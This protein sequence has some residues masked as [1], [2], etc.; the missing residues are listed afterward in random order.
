V[1][2]ACGLQPQGRWFDPSRAHRTPPANCALIRF[3]VIRPAETLLA[4]SHE[5]RLAV[6]VPDLFFRKPN[7]AVK[8]DDQYVDGRG[9]KI[10]ARVYIRHGTSLGTPGYLF[11]HGGGLIDGGVAHW[12]HI[13]RMS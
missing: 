8:T 10:H 3:K 2:R 6:T 13:S 7:P 1:V 4:K 12:D 5:Q 9:G 11:S